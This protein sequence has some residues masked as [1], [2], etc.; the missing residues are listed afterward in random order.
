MQDEGKHPECDCAVEIESLGKT[1]VTLQIKEG[2]YNPKYLSLKTSEIRPLAE[3]KLKLLKRLMNMYYARVT[4]CPLFFH[5]LT[6]FISPFINTQRRYRL[7]MLQFSFK[8][9]ALLKFFMTEP[10]ALFFEIKI[11]SPQS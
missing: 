4:K 8:Q 11:W 5:L 6:F 2:G 7:N 3:Q 9:T 10:S 1:N